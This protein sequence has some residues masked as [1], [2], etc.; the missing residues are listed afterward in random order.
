MQDSPTADVAL[1]Q[2]RCPNLWGYVVHLRHL[3]GVGAQEH[4]PMKNIHNGDQKGT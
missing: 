3:V 4:Y 2:G 1:S